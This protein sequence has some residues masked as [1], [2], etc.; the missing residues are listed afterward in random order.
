MPFLFFCGMAFGGGFCPAGR[1]PLDFWGEFRPPGRG[2]RSGCG[3]VAASG[4]GRIICPL[5]FFG[6]CSAPR[7]GP[8][9]ARPKRGE[10][11]VRGTPPNA[12]V[13]WRM[14][15]CASAEKLPFGLCRSVQ[16]LSRTTSAAAPRRR[17]QLTWRQLRLKYI[18]VNGAVVTC[19]HR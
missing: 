4:K 19:G 6:E 8:L 14:L 17:Y 10:K 15:D 16:D 7:G 5:D 2:S 13:F 1:G 12:P 11:G 18:S 3:C 9:F